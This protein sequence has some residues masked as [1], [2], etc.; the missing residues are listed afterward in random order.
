MY[1]CITNSIYTSQTV[2]IY[3]CSSNIPRFLCDYFH[4]DQTQYI[5][6]KAKFHSFHTCNKPSRYTEWTSEYVSMVNHQPN[7]FQRRMFYYQLKTLS[8]STLMFLYLIKSEVRH[9]EDFK[10]VIQ[11]EIYL[12]CSQQKAYMI[13]ESCFHMQF[14]Y[15][16]QTD[17]CEVFGV[18]TQ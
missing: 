17:I 14:S 7:V 3:I 15:Q 1:L 18:K 9:F 10:F 8:F 5:V 11:L 13:I 6:N 12:L 16:E 4:T 2:Y